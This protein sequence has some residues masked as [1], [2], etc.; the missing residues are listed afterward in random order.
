M[1]TAIEKLKDE[2]G[3]FTQ[4]ELRAQFNRQELAEISYTLQD[5]R[6]A[7]RVASFD[8]GPFYWLTSGLTRTENP[9]YEAQGL[10]F[11]AP[12]PNKNYLI[13]LFNEFLAVTMD[14]PLFIPKSRTMLTSLSAQGFA[15]LAAQWH[16]MQTLVQTLDEDRCIFLMSYVHAYYDL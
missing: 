14:H 2:L 16:G 7:E 13:P 5:A 12:L 4:E 6:C 1:P 8:A 9:Q 15:T 10:P 3:K 11:R